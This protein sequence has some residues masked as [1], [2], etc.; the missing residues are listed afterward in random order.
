[1]SDERLNFSTLRCQLSRD[2]GT[3]LESLIRESFL[4]EGI[5]ISIRDFSKELSEKAKRKED[6]SSDLAIL[7]ELTRILLGFIAKSIGSNEALVM[8]SLFRSL[9][10]VD[11]LEESSVDTELLEKFTQVLTKIVLSRDSVIKWEKRSEEILRDLYGIYP[12][13]VYFNIFESKEKVL[14][15]YVFLMN[16]PDE[17]QLAGL[18]LK[19]HDE[20]KKCFEISDILDTIPMEFIIIPIFTGKDKTEFKDKIMI[21]SHEYLTETPGIGGILGMGVFYQNSMNKRDT[22]IINSLLSIMTMVTGSARALSKAINELEFYAGHDPLT[23]LYN[24]R[25]FEHFLDYEIARV[26]RKNYKFSLMMQD[27]DDFKYVNDNYG[28]PFGD[29]FLKEVAQTLEDVLRDGDVVARLGGD[30]F[31]VILSET[32]IT[33]GKAVAEKLRSAF[34]HKKI[35]TPDKK[36]IPIKASIGLVEFPT[37]GSTAAELMVVVDAALYNAKELGKNKVFVPTDTEIKKSLKEQT[38]KFNLLQ[39]ALEN[40]RFVPYYQPIFDIAANK[41]TAYEV[42]ARLI[43]KDGN[44]IPAY[45]FIDMSERIGKIFYIDRMVITKAFRNKKLKNNHNYLF[46]NI[47]GKELKDRTFLE[48]IIEEAKRAELNSSEIVI[49]ITEREAA[50]D[51]TKI[52]DFLQVVISNGFKLAIDDF[53]SGYSSFYYLKYLPAHF[54]KIDGEFIKELATEDPRDYAFVESIQTLCKK[55]NIQTVAEFVESSRILEIV[56]EIGITYGQGFHLGM[57]HNDFVNI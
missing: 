45:K 18:K 31:A 2:D 19:I 43:D 3:V 55:L 24:R 27:L 13:D 44:V 52:Q 50:G 42:L 29:L 15:A 4:I 21:N 30:E 37:H 32:D 8:Q 25:M 9:K 39:D 57:P 53:G 33:K 17:K 23:G 38:E 22:D 47:S 49:E 35:E 54:L 36:I 46:V 20:V 11:A 28:H 41:I 16:E 51:L 5:D 1:M 56:G 6:I 26:K 34:E 7:V 10:V 14:D 40:S 48:F 12:F